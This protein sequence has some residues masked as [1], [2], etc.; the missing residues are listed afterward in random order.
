MARA[1]FRKQYLII[2]VALFTLIF[3]ASLYVVKAE[4]KSQYMDR[5][6]KA[7]DDSDAKIKQGY[8]FFSFAEDITREQAAGILK[9]YDLTLEKGEICAEEQGPNEPQRAE[10]KCQVTDSW[11]DGIKGARVQ[12]PVGKEK[13]Y[14]RMLVEKESKVIFAEPEYI[15][16]L[17]SGLA[18]D[19]TKKQTEEI[20]PSSPTT[21]TWLQKLISV[22]SSFFRNLF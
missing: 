3:F 18:T 20:S 22:F 14:A 5:M 15:D 4:D 6:L 12:V 7:F 16:Q 11:I 8:V 9:K 21:E 17:S 10:T 19:E 1:F 13:D 2:L